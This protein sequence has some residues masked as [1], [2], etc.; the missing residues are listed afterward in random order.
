MQ[1]DYSTT[2]Q[3]RKTKTRRL[4]TSV[5]YAFFLPLF[6]NRVV[7]LRVSSLP[8]FC[9]LYR[10][11]PT[12]NEVLLKLP[13]LFCCFGGSKTQKLNSKQ[14]ITICDLQTSR[15]LSSSV[16]EVLLPSK[17]PLASKRSLFFISSTK[18][19]V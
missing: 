2:E 17:F 5:V 14:I 7:F 19:H 3:W 6:C 11:T 10:S 9:T 13:S 1:E 8:C 18:F 12:R 15:Q 16:I 4:H